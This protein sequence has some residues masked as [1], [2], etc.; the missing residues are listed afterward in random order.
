MRLVFVPTALWVFF[1]RIGHANTQLRDFVMDTAWRGPNTLIIRKSGSIRARNGPKR[2]KRK[3][4]KEKRKKKLLLLLGLGRAAIK[5]FAEKARSQASSRYPV[6]HILRRLID[7]NGRAAVKLFAEI[8]RSQASSRHVPCRAYLE[9]PNRHQPD[10]STER[11]LSKT[12][13]S[14]VSLFTRRPYIYVYI[15]IHT[16]IYICVC[17]CV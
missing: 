2:R 10:C 9:A 16:Y 7:T 3:K 5:L 17:V 4:K 14:C 15:Y 1:R 6:G 8:A 13:E 11:Y 12:S